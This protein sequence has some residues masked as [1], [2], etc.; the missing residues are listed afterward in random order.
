MYLSCSAY[1][2][3]R[4]SLGDYQKLL[5]HLRQQVIEGSRWISR[6]ASSF[7]RHFSDVRS[8]V[9]SHAYDEHTDYT[10]LEKDF[11]ATG[12]DITD[13]QQGTRNIGTEAL[14]GFLMYRAS[15]PNPIDLIGAMW[16]IEGLGNK[17]ASEWSAHVEALA[18]STEPH[19]QFMQYH[20]DNDTEHL[21]KTLCLVKI[22]FVNLNKT[23][24]TLHV[25]PKW[26]QNCTVCN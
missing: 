26:W 12:G 17:M 20:A 4:L 21:E 2:K 18:L 13:I 5:L 1:S 8:V 6:S 3:Q 16:I 25:P 19:T 9:I 10:M 11:T 15:L 23:C 14:H 22:V 7:D 24:K